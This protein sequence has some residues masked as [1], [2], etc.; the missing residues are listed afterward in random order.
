MTYQWAIVGGTQPCRTV[1]HHHY[2]ETVRLCAAMTGI[3]MAHATTFPSFPDSDHLAD[4]DFRDERPVTDRSRAYL[5]AL[6]AIQVDHGSHGRDRVPGIPS[7]KL[8]SADHWHVTAPECIEALAAYDAARRT[9]FPL[10]ARL[11]DDIVPFL[12]HAARSSGFRVS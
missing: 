2:A 9:G 3:G 11:A 4:A 10:P 12:R 5:R 6:R 7:H 8:S 1:T